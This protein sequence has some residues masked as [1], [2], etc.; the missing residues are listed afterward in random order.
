ML[1]I[2]RI[3]NVTV[4]N[5]CGLNDHGIPERKSMFLM[6][7]NCSHHNFKVWDDSVKRRNIMNEFNCFIGG[8]REWETSVGTQSIA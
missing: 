3:K 8:K 4:R 5:D 1:E 2:F 6:Q 7:S